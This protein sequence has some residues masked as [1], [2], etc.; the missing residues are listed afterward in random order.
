EALY[1]IR[2]AVPSHIPVMLDAKRNDL[3]NTSTFSSRAIFDIWGFDAVTVNP[4]LGREG[5]E[6]YLGYRDKGVF[7]LCRT[8]NSGA[9]DFQDLQVLGAD[10]AHRPLY[11]VVAETVRGWNE[12]GNVGLV[13]GATYPAEMQRIRAICPDMPFLIPGIGAQG[14]DLQA[15]LEAGL[16]V[17]GEGILINSSRQIIY[18]SRSSADYGEAARAAAIKLRD[19]I[20]GG[21]AALQAR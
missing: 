16:D 18:A 9:R 20:N 13:V 17:R 10:G 12:Y 21:R 4:Y 15:S 6:P 2:K 7:V 3:G 1:Q 5:L 11:E 8:S 19:G 14:G